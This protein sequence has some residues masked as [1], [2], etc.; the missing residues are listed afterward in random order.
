MKCYV[1]AGSVGMEWT[2]KRD[3]VERFVPFSSESEGYRGSWSKE[4]DSGLYVYVCRMLRVLVTHV[5]LAVAKLA[6]CSCT[7]VALAKH[8][9]ELEHIC[10]V[11]A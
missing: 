9:S 7:V 6:I 5:S 3:K 4:G 10:C 2:I 8:S 11:F 1:I